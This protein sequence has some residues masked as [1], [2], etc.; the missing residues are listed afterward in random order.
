MARL[1]LGEALRFWETI[2]SCREAQKAGRDPS[3]RQLEGLSRM[4]RQGVVTITQVC[5]PMAL[6]CGGF[7]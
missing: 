2:E 1:G 6:G 4:V 5:G 7:K 3:L